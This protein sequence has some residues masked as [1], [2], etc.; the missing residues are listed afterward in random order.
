MPPAERRGS[1]IWRASPSVHLLKGYSNQSH[2]PWPVA[3]DWQHSD[4][5]AALAESEPAWKG[6]KC[7]ALAQARMAS[8]SRDPGTFA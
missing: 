6:R 5:V 7:A 8:R 4:I 1:R 2:Y 3:H